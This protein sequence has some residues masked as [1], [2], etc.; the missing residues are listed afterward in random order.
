VLP[1]LLLGLELLAA[2]VTVLRAAAVRSGLLGVAAAAYAGLLVL[3]TWQALRGQSIV[4]P[5]ATTLAGFAAVL[6]GA[7]AGA[8]LVVR[9]RRA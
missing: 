2:R 9:R 6:L 3:L 1:L 8:V 7:G 4:A 5:D